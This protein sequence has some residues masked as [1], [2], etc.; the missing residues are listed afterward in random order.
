MHDA[1]P[2][3]RAAMEESVR[4]RHRATSC[5]SA[6]DR[7]AVARTKSAESEA[8]LAPRAACRCRASSRVAPPLEQ[9]FDGGRAHADAWRA[10]HA[11][12]ARTCLALGLSLLWVHQVVA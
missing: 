11:R 4:R 6:P 1:A 5:G 3:A 10:R 2:S 9:G 8:A 7:G 12:G